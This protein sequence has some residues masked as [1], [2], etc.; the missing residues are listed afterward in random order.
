MEPEGTSVEQWAWREII[1]LERKCLARMARRPKCSL[2]GAPMV[3]GQ[4]EAHLT[5]QASLAVGAQERL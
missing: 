1:R 5:C 2:C 4:Q 3:C